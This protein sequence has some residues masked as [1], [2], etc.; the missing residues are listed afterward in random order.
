MGIAGSPLIACGKKCDPSYISGC[1]VAEFSFSNGLA[2]SNE[3][4]HSLMPQ[5]FPP[6]SLMVGKIEEIPFL[7]AYFS[8]FPEECA[9]SF[10]VK[11]GKAWSLKSALET[12]KPSILE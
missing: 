9:I 10:L 6:T 5:V 11:V 1:L 4:R 12:Q 8:Y 7:A 2:V 3:Q